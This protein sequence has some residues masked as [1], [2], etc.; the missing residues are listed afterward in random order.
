MS[1]CGH[2]E[3]RQSVSHFR[4]NETINYLGLETFSENQKA[5]KSHCGRSETIQ[6]VSHF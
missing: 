4:H 6:N 5:D 2:S 1:H 3:T